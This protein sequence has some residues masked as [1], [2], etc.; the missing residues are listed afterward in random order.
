MEEE[1]IYVEVVGKYMFG[2]A[3]RFTL[4]KYK[5]LRHA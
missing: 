1:E 3:I 5:L 2:G 4:M